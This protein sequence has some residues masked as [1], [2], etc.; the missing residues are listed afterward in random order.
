MRAGLSDG[1]FPARPHSAAHLTTFEKTQ[2]ELTKATNWAGVAVYN[3]DARGE[4]SLSVD[5]R[6]AHDKSFGDG[7]SCALHVTAP[8]AGQST[9]IFLLPLRS[10]FKNSD[11]ISRALFTLMRAAHGTNQ[12]QLSAT[13]TALAAAGLQRHGWATLRRQGRTYSIPYVDN[14]PIYALIP[15]GA[16]RPSFGAL[17]DASAIPN[18]F[19]DERQQFDTRHVKSSIHMKESWSPFAEGRFGIHTAGNLLALLDPFTHHG[20]DGFR[21]LIHLLWIDTGRYNVATKDT[22]I[23]ELRIHSHG[24]A[25]EIL[26]GDDEIR[27]LRFSAEWHGESEYAAFGSSRRLKAGDVQ[28]KHD[29]LRRMPCRRR[30]PSAEYFAEFGA[31]YYR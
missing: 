21:E 1:A 23:S 24:N 13:A 9:T 31:E 3:D 20:V 4:F 8:I 25:H 6:P 16:E 28:A 17:S 5:V 14:R 26:M 12:G 11:E 27:R 18:T 22:C 2:I 7:A 30:D 10:A 15:E 19:A 29:N